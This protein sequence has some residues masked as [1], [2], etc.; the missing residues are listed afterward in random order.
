MEKTSVKTYHVFRGVE[1]IYY[2]IAP[3]SLE[4][5]DMDGDVIEIN[6]CI[7]GRCECVFNGRTYACLTKGAVSVNTFPQDK[8]L[9]VFPDSH[10]KGIAVMLRKNLLSD[11]IKETFETLGIDIDALYSRICGMSNRCCIIKP[12]GNIEHIYSELYTV[13][14][15]RKEAYLKLKVLEL[16]MFLSDLEFDCCSCFY[17]GEYIEK[18]RAIREYI[19][20]DPCCHH[21]LNELSRSFD[22]PLTAMKKCFKS[23]YGT[24]IY[25]YFRHC[26]IAFA[27]EHLKKD[28]S[29]SEAA[30]AAGYE[31]P[32]KFSTAFKD[33]MGITPSEYKRSV[34]L[35]RKKSDR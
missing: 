12:G 18:V 17:S 24:T 5:H 26:R 6:H 23:I 28:S 21:T 22:I 14:E 31:N 34:R 2:T 29:V 30:E 15:E 8:H 3:C 11:G 33:E 9:S 19:Q 16:L 7:H 10:Y 27:L 25:A 32:N 1:V 35:D 13:K 4:A 20:A